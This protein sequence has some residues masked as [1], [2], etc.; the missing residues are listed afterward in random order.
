[1][2]K[3]FSRFLLLRVMGFTVNVKEPIPQKFI[4]ALAPHT[5]NWD[6]VI[7]NLYSRAMDIPCQFLMKKEWFIWPLGYIMKSLGGIP[8]DRSKRTRV[9]EQ[10]AQTAREQDVFHLCITPEGTRKRNPEWKKGFYYIALMADIPILLYGLDY[11]RRLIECTKTIVPSGDIEKDMAE[12]KSY[13]KN[14]NGKH[15]EKFA[16]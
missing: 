14:Y 4:I 2:I 10:I 6:F 16:L 8:I 15:P 9:T 5:S 12:I 1:M 7:G 13:F 3:A 11:R